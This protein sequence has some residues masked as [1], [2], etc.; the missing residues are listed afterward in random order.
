MA[1]ISAGL[2]SLQ[3][4]VIIHLGH[5]GGICPGPLT[6]GEMQE[7][8]DDDEDTVDKDEEWEDEDEFVLQDVPETTH[9]HLAHRLP[10]PDISMED[11]TE[12]NIADTEMIIVDRSG[13][14]TLGVR[15]CR[16]HAAPPKDMQ[17]LDA[18]LFPASF[19]RIKTCFTFHVLD[20]FALEN[21]E[22]KTSCMSFYSK[23]RRLTSPAFPFTVLVILFSHTHCNRSDQRDE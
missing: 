6:V 12:E 3:V 18:S 1:I 16:C 5:G 13:V 11:N 4:G 22:C 9:P 14:H 10:P 7:D 21:L 8:L 19:T 2:D 15:W 17:L 23:L 20:D